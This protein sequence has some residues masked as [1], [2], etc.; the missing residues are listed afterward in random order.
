MREM[1]YYVKSQTNK[2]KKKKK[3]QTV[4]YNQ[5]RCFE[6]DFW[7]QMITETIRCDRLK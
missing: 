5:L 1:I 3:E 6:K 7:K 2:Q 4:T